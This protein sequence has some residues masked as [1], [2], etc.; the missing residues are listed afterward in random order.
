MFCASRV[1]DSKLLTTIVQK[2]NVSL[3]ESAD[4]AKLVSLCR[5]EDR[6]LIAASGKQPIK[7]VLIS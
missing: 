2:Q 1:E 3:R 5:D 6:D 4:I 7:V